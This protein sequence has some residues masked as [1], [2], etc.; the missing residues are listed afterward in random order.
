ML[1]YA[2]Y[3]G[4]NAKKKKKKKKK[5]GKEFGLINKLN[6]HGEGRGKVFFTVLLSYSCS[7]WPLF[8]VNTIPTIM[9]SEKRQC[10]YSK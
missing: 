5:K 8:V 4:K 10:M 3:G 2:F 1:R 7:P 6:S 9:E